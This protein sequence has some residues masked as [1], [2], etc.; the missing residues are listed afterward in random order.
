M[1]EK[2]PR[3]GLSPSGTRAQGQQKRRHPLLVKAGGQVPDEGLQA[4]A[5]G[6]LAAGGH[7][8]RAHRQ[9]QRGRRLR[10]G[11]PAAERAAGSALHPR[12]EGA[13]PRAPHSKKHRKD[14]RGLRQ[15]CPG[16]TLSGAG[17]GRARVMPEHPRP[18]ASPGTTG[19]RAH[20]HCSCASR[21][22]PARPA[23][24]SAQAGRSPSEPPGRWPRRRLPSRPPPRPLPRPSRLPQA[25]YREYLTAPT[26][27]Q[28]R[29]AE[30]WGGGYPSGNG[31]Q[32]MLQEQR[33]LCGAA[34]PD[35]ARKC[36][37]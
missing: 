32:D 28:A 20:G 8:G 16:R 13:G 7:A 9:R 36:R 3:S 33:V 1:T 37:Q 5:P 11:A 27:R 22:G 19:P 26:R 35:A 24:V 15:A 2:A 30:A 10:P 31:K 17:P 6:T 29:A 34:R 25:G 14:P 4:G 23:P 18:V 12:T 21:P